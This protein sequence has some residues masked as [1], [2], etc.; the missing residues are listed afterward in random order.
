MKTPLRLLL[1]GLC[2]SSLLC[3]QTARADDTSTPPPGSP[4]GSGWMHKPHLPPGFDQLNLSDA[5]KAAIL[6]IIQDTEA[7]RRQKIDQLLT[8]DQKAKLEQLKAEHHAHEGGAGNPPPPP[9]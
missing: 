4:P 7:E 2:A 3:L 1:L 8:A 5:Q 6:Q 9:Q